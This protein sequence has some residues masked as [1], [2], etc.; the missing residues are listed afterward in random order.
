MGFRYNLNTVTTNF[1][2]TNENDIE[3]E[4]EEFHE[5]VDFLQEVG[6]YREEDEPSDKQLTTIISNLIDIEEDNT[7]MSQDSTQMSQE[8]TQMSQK[9][10]DHSHVRNVISETHASVKPKHTL[11]FTTDNAKDISKAIKGTYQWLGCSAH[12]INLV[13]KEDFKNNSTG[14]HLF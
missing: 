6:Y 13:I 7:Q 14:A 5:E 10:T 12:H 8:D 1:N 11:S 9:E 3:A 4:I 2:S